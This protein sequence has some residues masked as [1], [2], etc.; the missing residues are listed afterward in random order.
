VE[1]GCLYN[2]LNE[3]GVNWDLAN[4]DDSEVWADLELL[5]EKVDGLTK[6]L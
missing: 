3:A 1:I 5:Q 4:Q 2:T 6:R